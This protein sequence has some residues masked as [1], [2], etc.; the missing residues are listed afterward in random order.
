MPLYVFALMDA[1]PAGAGGRGLHAALTF[2]QVAG[3][4]A[5]VERRAD[6]PPIEL[7]SLT[8]H[9]RIVERLAGRVPAILPVR[10]GTLLTPDELQETLE[11]RDDELAD[12]LDYV[13]GRTQMTWRLRRAAANPHA[14]STRAPVLSGTEYL[15]RA[16]RASSS[17]PSPAFRSIRERLG[18]LAVGERH[19]QLTSSLPESLYHLIDKARSDEYAQAARDVRASARTLTVSGP[20]APYV[21][22]PDLF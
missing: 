5:A 16:K 8:S 1:A 10:F 21:F 17:A 9:Q 20:W 22:V 19:Q 3:V 4:F 12:A 2:R 11:E 13:R 14:R 15:Q 18:P 7:G 6:V